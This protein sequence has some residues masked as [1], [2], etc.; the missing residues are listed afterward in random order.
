ML[1]LSVVVGRL[2]RDPELRTTQGGQEM[3]QLSVATSRRVKRGEAWED[4]TEWH[5]VVL[6]G[7]PATYAGERARKG[8]LVLVI[9]EPRSRTWED[10]QGSKRHAHG[11]VVGGPQHVFKRLLPSAYASAGGSGTEEETAAATAAARAEAPAPR[12]R[13][14]APAG[15]AMAELT[16]GLPF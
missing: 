12:E 4:Q 14:R 6:W 5:N 9:G 3:A 1:S 15:R 16:E 7:Q 13:R 8:D 2:G 11:I 10:A